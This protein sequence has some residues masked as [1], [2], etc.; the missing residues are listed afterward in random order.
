[1]PFRMRLAGTHI[2]ECGP[3]QN[4]NF[5]EADTRNGVHLSSGTQHS[6]SPVDGAEASGETDT[7]SYVRGVHEPIPISE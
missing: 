5:G 6:P 2:E 1:V 3:T 4:V 7:M